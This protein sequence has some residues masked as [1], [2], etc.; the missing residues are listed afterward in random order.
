MD[1][2][3]L[4]DCSAWKAWHDRMPGSQA[5]LHITGQ[6]TF[7]TGGYAVE[8]RPMAP[9]GI[10]PKIYILNKIVNEP[11]GPVP[12]VL[13]VVDVSYLENTD[14]TYEQVHILPDDELIPV[15]EVS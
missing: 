5:T 15:E 6:C 10:N 3:V 9:Q 4:G 14:A 13:T 8:L 2:N 1:T 7:P 11:T 12:Q